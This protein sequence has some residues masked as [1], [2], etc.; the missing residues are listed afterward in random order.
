MAATIE[1]PEHLFERI[2]KQA[3]PFVDLNPAA[4]IQRWADFY[5]ASSGVIEAPQSLEQKPANPSFEGKRYNP[6]NPPELFHTRV[7]GHIGGRAYR[8]WNDLVR[9]AHQLAIQRSGSIE[10]LKRISRANVLPGNHAGHRGFHYVPE[11]D[12]SI[13]GMDSNR[14]WECSFHLAK[15][16]EVPIAAR[17]TWLDKPEAA[18]PGETGVLEWTP[19]V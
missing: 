4:V 18:F 10:E 1:I 19:Q 8:K 9:L 11:L 15:Y 12:A 16:V 13:S 14:C 7:S 6:M 5:D 17:F 3:I 2:Q